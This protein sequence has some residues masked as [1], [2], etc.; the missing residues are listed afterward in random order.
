[1]GRSDPLD[2]NPVAQGE[3][4]RR[5]NLVRPRQIVWLRSALCEGTA[6]LN[7]GGSVRGGT[8]WGSLELTEIDAPGVVSTGVWVGDGLRSMGKPP[9]AK[10]WLGETQGRECGCG[11]GSRWRCSPACG[12]QAILG[13]GCGAKGCTCVCGVNANPN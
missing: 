8:A 7:A 3:G 10:A 4:V 6:A 12:V 13:A 11:G 2:L 9:G 1:M 5:S